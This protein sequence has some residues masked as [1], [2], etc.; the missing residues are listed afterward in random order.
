MGLGTNSK[1][2]W[3]GMRI[4][5]LEKYKY[6]C[7]HHDLKDEIFKMTQKEDGN[8]ND[9]VKIFVYYVKREKLHNLGFDT[10]TTLLLKVIR[11]E[12]IDLLNLM[13]KGDM[14]QFSFEE[15]CEFCKHISRG[16]QCMA[17]I[18]EI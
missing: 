14:S 4:L 12:W 1:R 18:L 17:K 10:L 13:G 5:I 9:L 2:S 7:M 6:Y 11:D 16:K 8:L 15:M 3:D